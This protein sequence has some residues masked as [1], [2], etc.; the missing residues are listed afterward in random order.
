M[1]FYK[2]FSEFIN[3]LFLISFLRCIIYFLEYKNYYVIKK[4]LQFSVNNIFSKN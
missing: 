3:K 1:F 2:I 4:E